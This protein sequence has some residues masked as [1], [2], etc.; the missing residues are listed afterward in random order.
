[1]QRLVKIVKDVEEIFPQYRPVVG[2]I[3]EANYTP[4]T[5]TKY[6]AGIGEFCVI[7]ILDKKIVLRRNEF[8][9]VNYELSE[10][11]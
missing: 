11:L 7:D 10:V 6:G 3:Y 4:R 9:V 8:E 5:V 2:K 1:M